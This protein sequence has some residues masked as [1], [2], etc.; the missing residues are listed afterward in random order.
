[1]SMKQLVTTISA[2]CGVEDD[3]VMYTFLCLFIQTPDTWNFLLPRVFSFLHYYSHSSY[4][5]RPEKLKEQRVGR[6]VGQL[7]YVLD[8]KLN[9]HPTMLLYQGYLIDWNK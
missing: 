9:A 8:T 1:M 4:E 6:I 5:K 7:A 2:P 3:R